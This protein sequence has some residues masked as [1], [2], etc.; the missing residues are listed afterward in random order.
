MWAGIWL[1]LKGWL[2]M[3]GAALLV[4]AG[5]Y[6][7]GGRAARR[8]AALDAAKKNLDIKRRADRVAQEI[9]SLDDAAIRR[10]A[11]RWVRGGGR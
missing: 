2:L 8:S 1:R 4:L 9:D 11:R 7:A 3:V 10:R 5:A 6:A